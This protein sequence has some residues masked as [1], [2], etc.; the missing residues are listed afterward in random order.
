MIKLDE[1][2][3]IV[4]GWKL[5]V[6]DIFAEQ[7]E[8]LTQEVEALAKKDPDNFDSHPKY[9]LLIAIEENIYKKIPLNPNDVK[10]RLGSTLGKKHTHWRR[11]K[12]NNLPDRYRLFFQ[13]RSDS[14]AI[15]YAWFNDESNLRKDGAKTDVYTV[16]EVMLKNGNPPTTWEE[17]VK[18][19]ATLKAKT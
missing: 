6:S 9:K 17:L 18:K 16:F 10:Y 1:P 13:F 19:A 8:K 11:V 2:D 5:Y 4:N 14:K 3:A 7:L 12:K 15:I